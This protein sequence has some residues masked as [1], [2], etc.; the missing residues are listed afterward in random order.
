MAKY[1]YYAVRRG[2]QSGVYKTW[3]EC[4]KNVK[5]YPGA[6]FKGFRTKREAEEYVVAHGSERQNTPPLVSKRIDEGKAVAYCDG[7]YSVKT[8]VYSYGLVV[9]TRDNIEFFADWYNDEEGVSMRNVAGEIKGAMAAMAYCLKHNITELILHY[10]Y[11]G[12]A[13][14]CTGEWRANKEGTREY[15]RFY[16]SVS[17]IVDIKFVKVK[18]H[19]GN[20]WNEKA[21]RLANEA[22][23]GKHR[24]FRS[25]RFPT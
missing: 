20:L 6:Q 17:K 10:D 9:H 24:P 13:L 2:Y 11:M 25:E 14:W 18:A 22:Q 21:D 8:G 19:S 16:D 4:E 5:G 1:N 3:R 12:I 15:K 7:S 23:M